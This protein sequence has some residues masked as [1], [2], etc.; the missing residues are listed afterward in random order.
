MW[1]GNFGNLLLGPL[2]FPPRLNEESYLEFLENTCPEVL[3]TFRANLCSVHDGA[4]PHVARQVLKYF[5]AVGL[6]WM[7]QLI[8]LLKLNILD[9]FFGI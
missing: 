1:A 5:K 4:S 9:F 2:V 7:G 3:V 6:Q 8:S